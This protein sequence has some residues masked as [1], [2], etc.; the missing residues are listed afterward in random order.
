MV[1]TENGAACASGRTVPDDVAIVGFDDIELC[2]H[3]EPPLSTVHQA[4]AELARTMV[5]LLLAMVDGRPA[6]GP[7]LIPTELVLRGSG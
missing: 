3:T 1:I 4:I 2:L 6:Q 7:H 5:N